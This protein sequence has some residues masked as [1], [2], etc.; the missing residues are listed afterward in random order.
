MQL[1]EV[2][3]KRRSIRKF[4][5]KPVSRE[6]LKELIKAAALAPTASNL[7]AW[8]FFVADDPKLVRP[9]RRRAYLYR[10]YGAVPEGELSGAPRIYS[11]GEAAFSGA[12]RDN[13]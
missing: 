2:I 12:V 6:I 1:T 13:R 8:R 10:G 9:L 7:Q 3:E 4:S 5:D 11:A